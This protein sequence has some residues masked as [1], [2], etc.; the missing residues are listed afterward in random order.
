MLNKTHVNISGGP[1]LN[2]FDDLINIL[3][4][5]CDRKAAPTSCLRLSIDCLSD[6]DRRI[7]GK[8]ARIILRVQV[9]HRLIL[10]NHAL[11]LLQVVFLQIL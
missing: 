9:K 6:W 11:P 3:V 5:S 8:T 10:L 7:L 1:S 2:T 4:G